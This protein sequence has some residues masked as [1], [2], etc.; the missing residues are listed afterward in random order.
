MIEE[1]ATTMFEDLTLVTPHVKDHQEHYRRSPKNIRDTLA[2]VIVLH[3][4]KTL[5]IVRIV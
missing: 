4:N 1:K 5:R 3:V 2:K